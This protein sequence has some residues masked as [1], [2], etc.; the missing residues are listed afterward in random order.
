MSSPSTCSLAF[1]DNR[2]DGEIVDP[3]EVP[4]ENVVMATKMEADVWDWLEPF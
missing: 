3:D 4:M 1:E 2:D